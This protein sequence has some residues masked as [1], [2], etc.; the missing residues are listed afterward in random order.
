MA[1]VLNMIFTKSGI[2]D[3]SKLDESDDDLFQSCSDGLTKEDLKELEKL[4]KEL[5]LD[6]L[7]NEFVQISDDLT[8][9]FTMIDLTDSNDGSEYQKVLDAEN[10]RKAAQI[11]EIATKVANAI[12]TPSLATI[13]DA[14]NIVQ[15]TFPDYTSIKC[16]TNTLNAAETTQKWADRMCS[17]IS[18]PLSYFSSAK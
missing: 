13:T 16:V 11:G 1:Q 10:R 5:D 9:E 17:A 12:L 2:P 8:N 14:S 6:K 4:K 15:Q 18:A 3:D 7:M